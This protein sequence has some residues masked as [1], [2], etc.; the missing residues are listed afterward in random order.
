VTAG[1][2]V[3]PAPGE[4]VAARPIVENGV[5]GDLTCLPDTTESPIRR[6]SAQFFRIL[7]LGNILKINQA[8]K[9]SEWR[10]TPGVS[11]DDHGVV[12]RIEGFY[13]IDTSQ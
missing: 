8:K 3:D 4:P 5:D 13:A 1:Q 10:M 2:L 12:G 9:M 11:G 7:V 6:Q